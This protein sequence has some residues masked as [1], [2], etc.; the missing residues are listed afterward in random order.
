MKLLTLVLLL[1]TLNVSASNDYIDVSKLSDK[2]KA[3]L[4]LKVA[5]HIEEQHQ[6]EQQPSIVPNPN[7][8]EQ[9][10][11][12]GEKIGKAFGGAAKEIGVAVNDFVKTPVGIMTMI[13]IVWNYMGSMIVHL[14]GGLF[15]LI[16]SIIFIRWWVKI[17]SNDEIIYDTEKTN[18][19][20]NYRIREIKRD[21][22]SDVSGASKT[23]YVAFVIVSIIVM[24]SGW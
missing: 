9:Y 3:E 18:I 17:S 2:D 1:F 6:K 24:F 23:L 19:F 20:G 21:V 16:T 12:V 13:L 4:Q 11:T 7:V 14:L 5:K 22:S 8:V 15:I 10:V